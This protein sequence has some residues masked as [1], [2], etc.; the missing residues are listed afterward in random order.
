MRRVTLALAIAALTAAACGDPSASAV[1][2]GPD[3]GGPDGGAGGPVV[4]TVRIVEDRWINPEDGSASASGQ[5]LGFVLDRPALAWHQEEAHVGA[6]TLLR[7]TPALC[8]PPCTDGVCLRPDT[9][10][11]LPAFRSAGRMTVTGLT[12][13]VT[14][15]GPDGY[16]TPMTQLPDELFADAAAV[17]VTLAGAAVPGFT[18]ATTGVPALVAAIGTKVTLL[19]HQDHTVTWTP[20]GGDARVRLTINANNRG[21]GAP[22]AAIIDCDVADATGQVTI[23]AALIDAFPATSAWTVCA[24]SD[25]PPSTLRR[26]HRATT[27]IAGGDAELIVGSQLSFG[28]EHAP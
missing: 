17:Q 7:Y 13:P 4:G 11:A 21:H 1:D 20:A 12:A 14:V 22:Y 18:L 26:Y 3:G 28:V 24:G 27:A 15:D 19:P 8:D 25:C 23:A 6:C 10:A 9:C 2:A 5:L 16:Y